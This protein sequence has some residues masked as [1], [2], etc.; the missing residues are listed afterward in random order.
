[1][2][3]GRQI[4]E[5]AGVLLLDVGYVRWPLAELAGW[6]NDGVKAIV[7]A[8]PSAASETRALTLVSGTRQT[9]PQSGGARTPLALLDI[10]RNLRSAE[11][12]VGGRPIRPVP[13]AVLD[14]QEPYW[15]DERRV[16]FARE[17]KHFIF[18]ERLPLEFYVYPG[19]DGTG[20]VEAMLSVLPVPLAP[21]GSPTLIGSWEGDVGLPEPF[22]TPLLDYVCWRAHSKDSLEAQAGKAQ[23]HYQAFASALGIKV[24]T[25]R[26]HAPSTQRTS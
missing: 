8:K 17:A 22:S 5:R 9:V 16:R 25:E 11:P 14:A 21:T 19:N 26:A 2:P 6:I 7:I 10:V 13:R 23:A 1:M 15:H 12:R 4:M 3:T 24:Q 20:I 18:D